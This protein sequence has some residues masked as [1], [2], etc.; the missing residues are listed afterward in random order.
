MK[1]AAA[2]L[3]V[4]L[5]GT[6]IPAVPPVPVSAETLND[7]RILVDINTNDGRTPSY[8][9]NAEN[10]IVPSGNSATTEI[11]GLTFTLSNGGTVGSGIRTGNCKILQRDDGS[12]PTLT[13]DGVYIEDGQNGGVVKL[14]IK[15]LSA[16]THSLKTFHSCMDNQTISTMSVTINGKKMAS[17]IKSVTRVTNDEEAGMSY[18]VFDVS[19][20][21]TV[22]V[23]ISPEGNGAINCA[24]LNA[25]E[26]DGADPFNGISR[27][28]PKDQEKH[29]EIEKG[30]SWTAGSGA[31]SHDVYIGTDFSAV[32]SADHSSA[33]FMGNQSASTYA[34]DSSYSSLKTYWWRVDEVSESGVTKGAVYRFQVAR[35]AFPTAEGYGRY[36]RGGRGGTVYHVTNLN[37]S[38]EGSLRYALET[39][40]GPRT[41]VFDVGGIIELKSKL[42]IPSDG[43]D[44]YIAGQTAPGQGITLIKYGLGAM[45]AEDIVIRDVHVRVGDSNGAGTD[46]MG[47]GSCDHCIVDHCSIS[48][49]TDEGFSSRG[50]RNITFQRNIIAESLNESVHYNANDRTQKEPHAFAASIGGE[51]GSFHHNLLVHCTD[52]NWSL[53][54]GMQQDGKSY[55]GCLDIIDNVVYNWRGRTT[56]GGI[57]RVNFINNYYKMGPESPD[58]WLLLLS[59]AALEQPMKAYVSGNK[60][61]KLNGSTVLDPSQD[62]WSKGYA[63][64]STQSE[65][66]S[67]SNVRFWESRITEESADA[68]YADVLSNVGANAQGLDQWDSRYINEV[69]NG[70]YTYTG[71]VDKLR[72]IIDSQNDVGG[73]PTS[74]T[75]KGGTAP[76]DSDGDGMSDA[77]ESAHGLNPNNAADGSIATLSADD[78]TNLEMYLNELAG[79]TVDYNAASALSGRLV[80]ELTVYDKTNRFNWSIEDNMTT[81]S[82][83]FGDREVQC[84]DGDALLCNRVCEPCHAVRA[85]ADDSNGM[86]F[87]GH[88]GR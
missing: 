17:G 24:Y 10:W 51:V 23:L 80:S 1:I 61:A 11:G 37:D 33:E 2:V 3:S 73:Y 64:S 87:C 8:T 42:T 58:M 26:I 56:D 7:A 82:L 25:F 67:R 36:A 47:L 43:G 62:A 75:F 19:A 83:M 60:L 79:D 41:V 15:G 65:A 57:H 68:A 53:A 77:W 59:D 54:G 86:V 31:V 18:S 4:M 50:A 45:G 30:L 76:A 9:S 70:T 52:R 72:G 71:S 78:Y 46:G 22:T 48:W 44:V 69:K 6:A 81:E 49:G 35:D 5:L 29:T 28:Y 14:E 55:R 20:G 16:G 63:K 21:E 32:L 27:M 34:L 88:L 84:F 66:D 12:T 39:L 13:M 38:G 74:S 40:K 85:L